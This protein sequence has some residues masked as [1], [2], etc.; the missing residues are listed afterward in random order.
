[1]DWGRGLAA[2]LHCIAFS[3]AVLIGVSK[4]GEIGVRWS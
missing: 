1:M 2:A 4:P 3:L